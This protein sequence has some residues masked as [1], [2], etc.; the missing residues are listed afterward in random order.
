MAPV[1]AQDPDLDDLLDTSSLVTT[2]PS[3]TS[4]AKG[5]EAIP[6][7]DLLLGP[8]DSK[9][10][11]PPVEQ[12]EAAEKTPAV[13][14]P[15]AMDPSQ[16]LR[17]LREENGTLRDKVLRADAEIAE[18]DIKIGELEDMV[19]NLNQESRKL[20]AEFTATMEE[21]T[22]AMQLL[23][24]KASVLQENLAQYERQANEEKMRS[25]SRQT[26]YQG[27]VNRYHEEGIEY[28]PA[29]IAWPVDAQ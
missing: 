11:S 15:V 24:T 25:S 5:S 7:E 2:S 3:E 10:S 28:I 18:R 4:S 26:K 17:K 29:T 1:A 21:Q 23:E 8:A 12:V 19:S 22:A 16:E 20:Q 13:E 14:S 27:V 9:E 6:Q